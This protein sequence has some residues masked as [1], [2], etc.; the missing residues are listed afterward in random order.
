MKAMIEKQKIFP[1]YFFN[2]IP[3]TE[4]S[5]TKYRFEDNGKITVESFMGEFLHIGPLELKNEKLL[6]VLVE[7]KEEK[8][9]IIYEFTL[10]SISVTFDFAFHPYK[11]KISIIGKLE[12][13]ATL[14]IPFSSSHKLKLE[15]EKKR[16]WAGRI[17]KDEVL[18]GVL[19]DYSDIPRVTFSD[20]KISVK[21]PNQFVLDPTTVSSTTT[22]AATQHPAQR[23]TFYANS[24]FWAFYSDGTNMVYRTSPDGVSWSPATTVRSASSGSYFSVKNYRL[25]VGWDLIDYVYYAYAPEATGTAVRFRRGAI[26]GNTIIWGTEYTAYTTPSDVEVG[27]PVVEVGTDNAVYVGFSRR[28]TTG[29]QYLEWYVV[30]N[31]NNDG[32]GSWSTYTFWVSALVGGGVWAFGDL[33]RLT[34][35]KIYT[36][37]TSGTVSWAKGAL[38]DGSS[39]GSVETIVNYS[40]EEPFGA[41]AY[42]DDVFFVY[43][44]PA[45]QIEFRIRDYSTSTWSSAETVDSLASIGVHLCIDQSTGDCWAFFPNGSIIYYRKRTYSTSSW[46]SQQTLA[47]GETDLSRASVIPFWV[48]TGDNIG[49]IWTRGIITKLV[50]YQVLSLAPPAPAP[51]VTLTHKIDHGPHPRSRCIFKRTLKLKPS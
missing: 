50:R 23:H 29:L 1:R 49:V 8:V 39:W 3:S 11:V 40:I 13:R 21:V 12:K 22:V 42:G 28:L 33:I 34:G 7:E 16:I 25:P 30:R 14:L 51:A 26:S 5:F 46:G 19:L 15:V 20:N 4:T 48:V 6:N 9:L 45:A 44:R 41:G 18:S 17:E 43:V 31:S 2:G 36:I 32:S 37:Y 27:K 24:Y 38:W 47:S 35:G 10:G